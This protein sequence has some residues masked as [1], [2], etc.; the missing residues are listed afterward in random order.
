LL[1]VKA[2]IRPLIRAG[3]NNSKKTA[4]VPSF[5]RDSAYHFIEKQVSFGARVPNTDPHKLCGRYLADKLREYGALV[6]EQEFVEQA[7][8]GTQVKS[9]K[10]H[11]H[12]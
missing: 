6:I 10:Y 3:L 4:T 8:D 5:H 11:W 7:Y 12:L 2:A 1:L 9:E